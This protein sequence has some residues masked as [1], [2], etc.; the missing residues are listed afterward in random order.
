M[1]EPRQRAVLIGPDVQQN[2]GG[3][4]Q[5]TT[6]L[7]NA[8]SE[9]CDLTF[10]SWLEI[11]PRFLFSRSAVA[12][13]DGLRSNVTAQA[14]LSFSRPSSWRSCAEKIA[15]LNPEKVFFTW[16][17]P[18]HAPIFI[19][20][21]K[22]LRT[23]VR[24]ELIL[25]CHN[26][27][28]HDRLP[29]ALKLTQKCFEH[30]DR[31]IVHSR[32]EAERLERFCIGVPSTVGFMPVFDFFQTPTS[33][34][35][36]ARAPRILFFGSIRPHKGLDLLLRAIPLVKN[37]HPD[38][39]VRIAGEE[40]FKKG[41]IAR[42]VLAR[43]APDPLE[44]I[45]TLELQDSVELDIR[46]IPDSEIPKVFSDVDAAIFPFR[47]ANQSASLSLA[48]SYGIPA[49]AP[50]VGFFPEVIAPDING[51]LVTPDSP[52]S[53]AEGIIRALSRRLPGSW[54]HS[55]AE[56]YSWSRYSELLLGGTASGFTD[57]AHQ[58]VNA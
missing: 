40:F 12:P 14:E 9:S 52:A 35:R 33:Q 15:A 24:S 55:H 16:T 34:P 4:A 42:R 57:R 36:A 37:V 39:R 43:S 38:I 30:F 22:R 50:R 8:L 17:H 5:F 19:A 7:A 32:Y 2:R 41:S 28:P 46:Y 29:G 58:M 51:V 44:L 26:V 45:Q 23:L 11:Y 56:E 3:I 48:F 53:L 27:M 49:V 47:A 1:S 31:L 6:R 25:I 21:A 13:S 10:F 20:I 18:V 54:V